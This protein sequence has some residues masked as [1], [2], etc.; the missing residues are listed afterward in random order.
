MT[1]FAAQRFRILISVTR[2]LIQ[3]RDAAL[4][5]A[6][7][8]PILSPP[9]EPGDESSPSKAISIPHRNRVLEAVFATPTAPSAAILLFHG[10]GERLSYWQSVQRLLTEHNIASLVFHYSGYGKSTGANTPQNLHQDA[11]AAYATLRSLLPESTPVHL[12]GFSL[13]SGIATDAAPHLSPRPA[14]LILCQPFTSLRA[15]ASCYVPAVLSPLLPDIWQTHRTIADISLP[16]LIVHSDADELF[17]FA[18]A[19]QIEAAAKLRPNHHTVD[20]IQPKGI[21]HNGAY[22]HPTLAYWQSIIDFALRLPS[23]LQTR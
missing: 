6:P 12:L 21:S 1:L 8:H 15:A 18:M 20:L 19:Q 7:T 2:R 17:P 11:H 5:A 23:P 13:G 4:I 22:L 14:G 3:A 9:P 16:L 10:I